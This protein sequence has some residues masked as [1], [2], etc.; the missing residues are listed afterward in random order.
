M[1]IDVN[2]L[3]E[4]VEERVQIFIVEH[5]WVNCKGHSSLTIA[6]GIRQ[7]WATI[8]ASHLQAV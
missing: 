2:L 7:N 8:L 3:R 1:H 6:F 4:N 5:V